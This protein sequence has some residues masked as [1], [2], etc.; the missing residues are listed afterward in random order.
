MDKYDEGYVKEAE[1]EI[2]EIRAAALKKAQKTHPEIR[3]VYDRRSFDDYCEKTWDY[4][5][6][7]YV[8]FRLPQGYETKEE[9]IDA[10]A[11]ETV[12]HFK[13]N[14][15]ECTS[16]RKRAENTVIV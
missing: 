8:S 9:L 2:E 16:A 14:G 10:L 13:Q 5:G 7:W 1:R 3:Y 6:K 4:P 15:A 11:E 12:R